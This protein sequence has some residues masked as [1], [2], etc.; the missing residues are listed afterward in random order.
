[1]KPSV[2]FVTG[3]VDHFCWKNIGVS[4]NNFLFLGVVILSATTHNP[5]II[6]MNTVLVL[7]LVRAA[8]MAM[9]ALA[10]Q[11]RGISYWK[12]RALEAEEVQSI[13]VERVKE[14]KVD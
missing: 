11:K 14:W 9:Q 1:M 5:I 3:K 8:S 2:R 12:C 4:V 6:I 7:L 13:L 10:K